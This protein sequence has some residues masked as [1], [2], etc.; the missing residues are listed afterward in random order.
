MTSQSKH[1]PTLEPADVAD[2]GV[3]HAQDLAFDAVRDLWQ[4]R[5]AEGM[6]QIDVAKAIGADPAWVSRKFRGPS[7]WTMRALGEL[8]QGLRGEMEIVVYAIEDSPHRRPNRTAYQDYQPIELSDQG[9]KVRI[10]T[11]GH[12]KGFNF[13]PAQ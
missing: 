7:N 12:V 10:E 5:S 2:Y 11:S 4:R 13:K 3:N 8:V 6:K 9:Q 1:I